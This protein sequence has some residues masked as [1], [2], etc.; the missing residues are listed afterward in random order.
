MWYAVI[1]SYTKQEEVLV[2]VRNQLGRDLEETR[3]DGI[4][5]Q[6]FFDTGDVELDIVPL[7]EAGWEVRRLT[8]DPRRGTGVSDSTLHDPT[9][10][11][12]PWYDDSPNDYC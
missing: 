11:V 10:N 8:G 5:S 7:K 6:L 1:V 4:A 9:T 12:L 2:I 3:Y